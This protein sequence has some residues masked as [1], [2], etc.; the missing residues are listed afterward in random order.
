MRNPNFK[1][2]TNPQDRRELK[3]LMWFITTEGMKIETGSNN[4]RSVDQVRHVQSNIILHIYN[5]GVTPL[6]YFG[7]VNE[8]LCY[9][10]ISVYK[11]INLLIANF[12]FVFNEKGR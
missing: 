1:C 9:V 10:A 8:M 3:V 4:S 7:H 5:K 6:Y 11:Q 12:T 2:N